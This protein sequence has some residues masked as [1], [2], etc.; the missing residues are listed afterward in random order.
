MFG[1]KY[2]ADLNQLFEDTDF[3]MEANT[4]PSSTLK[5]AFSRF[6]EAVNSGEKV[7]AVFDFDDTLATT[8]CNVVVKNQQGERRITP[9][10]FAVYDKKD[11]EEFDFREFDCVVNG[12]P[13]LSQFN[14]FKDF[15]KSNYTDT[16][17]LTARGSG[18]YEPIKE[19][20]QKNID[21]NLPDDKISN[22]IKQNKSIHNTLEIITVGSSS[23]ASKV[24]V[25]NQ[26]LKQTDYTKVMFMDDSPKNVNGMIEALKPYREKMDVEVYLI[27]N[28]KAELQTPEGD[29]EVA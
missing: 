23:P 20:V 15:I 25:V 13:I 18:A 29:A 6:E 28:E 7:L 14:L 16:M 12:K 3:K 24:E 1:K 11:D 26:K 4:F 21:M 10:E 8:D 17:I 9:A 5:E 2:Y 22:D 19:F 27:K